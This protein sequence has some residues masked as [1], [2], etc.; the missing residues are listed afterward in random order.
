MRYRL[1]PVRSFWNLAV[2]SNVCSSRSVS[3]SSWPSSR[4][5]SRLRMTGSDES[6]KPK[7][8]IW[9]RMPTLVLKWFEF[10]LS[11][12]SRSALALIRFCIDFHSLLEPKTAQ[13]EPKERLKV[14]LLSSVRTEN[15]IVKKSKFRNK[16]QKMAKPKWSF[17]I[18]CA[19]KKLYKS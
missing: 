4:K 10:S 18:N 12:H 13:D 3:D 6:R 11:D 7:A 9:C 1:F 14:K 15:S 17:N 8:F 5:P 16:C 2:S 19:T